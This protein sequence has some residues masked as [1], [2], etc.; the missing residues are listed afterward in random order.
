LYGSMKLVE[1]LTD[2]GK[3]ASLLQQGIN[4]GRREFFKVK[5]P[6]ARKVFLKGKA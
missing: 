2:K 4:E 6:G 5:L 3:H 1:E